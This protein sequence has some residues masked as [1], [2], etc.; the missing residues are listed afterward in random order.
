MADD[1]HDRR[2]ER[3]RRRRRE[4]TERHRELFDAVRKG[5]MDRADRISGIPPHGSELPAAPD[6]APLGAASPDRESKLEDARQRLWELMQAFAAFP[7]S[8][9]WLPWAQ[10]VYAELGALDLEAPETPAWVEALR[11]RLG[12]SG[13]TDLSVPA[14]LL[15]SAVFRLHG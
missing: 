14:L 4:D 7:W 3:M 15:D 12:E 5:Q 1:F 9:A 6:V 11:D 10:R 8:P 2:D 13:A